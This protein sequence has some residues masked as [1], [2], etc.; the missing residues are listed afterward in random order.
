M[1]FQQY[2]QRT[3]DTAIYPGAGTLTGL[4]YTTLGL[5]GESG[6][7]AN[8]V[9]KILRDDAGEITDERALRLVKELGDL[10]WYLA[11]TATEAGL[12]LDVIAGVNLE[13]LASR[14]ERGVLGGSGGDR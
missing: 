14:K 1:D 12:S 3:A 10:L 7:V 5:T 9:K 8:D 11:Q 2:Q 4:L 13:R 6:E